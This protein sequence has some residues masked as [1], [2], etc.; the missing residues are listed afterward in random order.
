MPTSEKVVA[1]PMAA[2]GIVVDVAIATVATSLQTQRRNQLF[3]IIESLHT[4]LPT[5]S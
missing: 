3:K 5:C 2:S 1:D 4:L